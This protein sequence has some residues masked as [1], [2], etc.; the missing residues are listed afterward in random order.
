MPCDPKGTLKIC[1][2]KLNLHMDI[3]QKGLGFKRNLKQKKCYDKIIKKCF[4][5]S[6]IKLET[7]KTEEFYLV[8]SLLDPTVQCQLN[9]CN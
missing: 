4:R 6:Y 2:S 8:V 3:K 5:F 1:V 7:S 9:D